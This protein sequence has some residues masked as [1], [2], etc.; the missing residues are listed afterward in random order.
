MSS[1]HTGGNQINRL[2]DKQLDLTLVAEMLNQKVDDVSQ[3][4]RVR[5]LKITGAILDVLAGQC[6]ELR[7]DA[8]R[9]L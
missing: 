3:L 5:L 2:K 8:E 1:S 6:G 7:S 9:S 4:E